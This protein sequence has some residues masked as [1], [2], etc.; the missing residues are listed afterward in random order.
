MKK[1]EN[2]APELP[3]DV[4]N[5]IAKK[6]DID[7]LFSFGKVNKNCWTCQSISWHNFLASQA[8]LVIQKTAQPK[9]ACSFFSIVESRMYNSLLTW[10]YN[11]NVYQSRNSA[12]TIYSR[13]SNPFTVVD[14]VV[15]N[16]RQLLV[17]H[18][19]ACTYLEVYKIDLSAMECT[20]IHMIGDCALFMSGTKCTSQSNPGIMGFNSNCVYSI[21]RIS[22]GCRVFALNNKLITTIP[23]LENQPPFIA[24]LCSSDWCFPHQRDEIDYT[25]HE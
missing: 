12:W 15:H 8:P 2:Y 24:R 20:R 13:W 7:D 18:F 25:C 9:R 23:L 22:P 14:V 19:K 3:M 21:D 17:L 11:L 1:G 5:I 4:L 16:H 6:L 10:G